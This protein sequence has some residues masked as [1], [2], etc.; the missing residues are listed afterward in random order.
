MKYLR[1]KGLLIAAVGLLVLCSSW[2]FLM[3]RTI[4]QLSVYQ[5][6]E[7]LKPFFYE[8]MD[9]LVRH[10][11][12]PDERR[13]KDSTEATKHFI[14][15]EAYGENAAHKM[16]TEWAQAVQRY[17]Q[18]TLLKYG[19][20]PYWIIVM[21]ER[22][23]NAFRSG[24]KDSILFYAADI[25]HYI[26]DVHV[27]LHT[28]INY[29]GQLTNQKG[30]HSLWESVVPELTLDQFNLKGHK[31][32]R[33]LKNPSPEIWKT[34]RYT[35]TLVP[36]VLEKEREV[37]RA[38]TDSTKYRY[39]LRNGREARYYTKEFALAYAKQ[40]EPTFNQQA[41]RSANLVADFWYTA[42][43]DAG[44]PELQKL[45][46]KAFDEAASTKLK[47]EVKAYRKNGL[48]NQGLLLSKKDAGRSE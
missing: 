30:I 4:T 5:L 23:T 17:S 22:L 7:G 10:S 32:A 14:D 42:W 46:T 34:V 8:N 36:G 29:D 18:D 35:F 37:S 28:T 21:Q 47:N 39:Q 43:V 41:I 48:L 40:L 15:F 31:K 9:Y 33:Y 6:P 24:N 38:F 20:V 45:M 13:N 1:R 3:H 19:Y 2:G 12:R 11:V 44:K 26:Q 27:P 16:P 25:A